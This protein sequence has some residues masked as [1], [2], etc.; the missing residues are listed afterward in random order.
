MTTKPAGVDAGP[1]VATVTRAWLPLAASWLLMAV[2]LPIV[3]AVTARMA[4][5]EV[6]LAAYGSVI[7]PIALVI[8]APIIMLLSA[9]TTLSRDRPSYAWL[10]RFT[11]VTS[12]ILTAL[13]L[14]LALT[15]LYAVVVDGWLG[16]P[17]EVSEAA[18]LGLLIMTPWT[19]AIAYRRFNQGVL[20]RFGHNEAVTVGTMLRLGALL[21]VLAIGWFVFRAGEGGITGATLAASAVACG[22]T[23]EAIY[24]GLRL[25]PV[26]RDELP[27]RDPEGDEGLRGRAFA[28]FYVPLAV[29]TLLALIGQPLGTAGVSRMPEVIPSLAVLPVVMGFIFM[30]QSQGLALTE[31][32]V[33]A[34]ERPGARRSLVQFVAR[35]C[36]ALAV[37][38]LVI[39][40]SGLSELWFV[41]VSGLEP[42]LGALATTGL[43]F[44]TPIPMLR[45]VQSWFSAVLVHA[46]ETRAIG[47]A[48]VV[49]LL[50][51]GVVMGVGILTQRWPG[52]YVAFA[53]L[54]VARACQTLW[55][56]VRS[57]SQVAALS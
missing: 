54:S 34:L 32:A 12:A 23:T 18:R 52:L 49:F 37:V 2:E 14:L 31:V 55:L 44:A 29:T 35:L 24:S 30:F 22:V 40:G 42:E 51:L 53:A 27:D 36:A 46:R 5:P 10:A 43:L 19:W 21:S 28:N 56:F 8:E 41:D 3:S 33:A 39:A 9:S 16:A 50:V 13:H 7:M 17:P 47:E 48:V 20:I 26:V 57:R 25:R 4:N 38:L 15:P 1:S 45:V 11:H 6:E